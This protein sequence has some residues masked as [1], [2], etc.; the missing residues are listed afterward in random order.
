LK[1]PL[2]VYFFSMLR[3]V[4]DAYKQQQAPT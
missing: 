4:P 2:S 3:V 1:T